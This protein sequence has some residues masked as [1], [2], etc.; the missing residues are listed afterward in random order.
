MVNS[1]SVYPPE[2]LNIWTSTMKKQAEL[3]SGKAKTVYTTDDPNRLIMHF[4]NDTSAFDGE[5][6]AQLERKGM[7]NN[8]FNAFIMQ[9]LEAGGIPTHFEKLLSEDESL[10]KKLDMLPVECVV[11]NISAGSL[12]RRLGVEEGLD[13]NPPTFEF[14]LK[15]DELH[16]P[17]INDSHILTF[18]WATQ[19]EIAQ[20]KA[21]TF[22]VNDIL[23]ALF[24]EAGMLLVDYKIEFGRYQ[25]SL[26]LGDEFSPDGCRLWDAETRKKLDKDR[27]RQGLG[28]VVEAYEEVAHRL[29]VNL[30]PIPGGD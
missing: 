19:D 2:K 1:L 9:K 24:S 16:D 4:R 30:E 17:M 21:L 25:G 18:K 11:R 13:L 27:F 10:F 14:F 7:V 20:M 6:V 23:K 28:G 26:L 12:C 3:Y 22:K 29:G 5:K 15:N 8:K